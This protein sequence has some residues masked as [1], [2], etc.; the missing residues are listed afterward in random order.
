MLF[1]EDRVLHTVISSS[2]AG[3]RTSTSR[4]VARYNS[5]RRRSIGCSPWALTKS[6]RATAP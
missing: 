1:V 6:F 2:I 4:R 3:I 5:G